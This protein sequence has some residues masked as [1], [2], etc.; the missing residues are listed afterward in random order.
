[1]WSIKWECVKNKKSGYMREMFNDGKV[2]Q[3]D[4]EEEVLRFLELIRKENNNEENLFKFIIQRYSGD[5]K[6]KFKVVKTSI[7][8][9]SADDV[10]AWMNYAV[11]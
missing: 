6:E 11:I 7:L 10:L 2:L 4:K 8:Q 9:R 5:R 3:F 1:M